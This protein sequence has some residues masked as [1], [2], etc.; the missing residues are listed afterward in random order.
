MKVILLKDA[1]KIGQRGDVIDVKDG[2]FRNYLLPNN[3]AEIATADKIKKHEH[4][5]VQKLEEKN[6]YGTEISKEFGR[7]NGLRLIFTAKATKKG[8]LYKM[9]SA[10]DIIEKISGL[11]FKAIKPDWIKIKDPLKKV[12]EHDVEILGPSGERGELKI[13]IKPQ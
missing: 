3:L 12:G 4:R 10:G 5:L 9:I 2:F 7:I 8:G 6:K 13:E 1:V 11:G